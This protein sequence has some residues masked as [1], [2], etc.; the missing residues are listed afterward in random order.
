M[1]K[2]FSFFCFCLFIVTGAV[3]AQTKKIIPKK[4]Q[5][6]FSSENIIQDETL[7]KSSL[8]KLQQK[9]IEA[10]RA[11]LKSNPDQNL[12]TT[13]L[14][15][16][17][18]NNII[19]NLI[20]QHKEKDRYHVY[21]NNSIKSFESDEGTD[22]SSFSNIDQN[23]STYKKTH[24]LNGGDV[25]ETNATAYEYRDDK[26]TIIK[27]FR[28]QQKNINGYNCFKVI[29]EYKTNFVGDEELGSLLET[30]EFAKTELWVTEEIQS[31]FHPICRIREILTKYYPL[32]ISETSPTLKGFL[33][34]HKLKNITLSN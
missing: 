12:D 14:Q 24:I 32:E 16:I 5:V 4:G 17:A 34:V 18:D 27:E 20:S 31:M 11:Q 15:Q 1:L 10:L 26:E 19:S 2:R 13:M 33:I 3:S 7:F 28:T 23:T 8:G 6:V 25:A 9:M 29:Y 30:N 22:P 21:E